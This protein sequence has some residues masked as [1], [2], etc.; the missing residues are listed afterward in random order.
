MTAAQNA[1]QYGQAAQQLGEQSRQYGAGL[2][3]QGLQTALQGA[4][5]LAGIGGQ[6]LQAQ[7][8]IL[9]L[10]QQAGAQQQQQ[11]QQVINQAIQNYANTIQYPQQQLSY[12]NS[13]LR[14]LPLS[15]T[16]QTAYQAPPSVTSQLAGLGLGAYG[17]SKIKKGGAIKAKAPDNRQKKPGG[18]MALALDQAGA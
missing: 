18:L 13:L 5:Q 15:Q 16:N 4:G 11:N 1:A 12:M 2:G 6:Q 3:L 9:G 10:Q 17:L 14:G 8:G 7:Q